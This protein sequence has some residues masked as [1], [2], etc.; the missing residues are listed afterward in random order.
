MTMV[1]EDSSHLPSPKLPSTYS[2]SS[3][4]GGRLQ[5]NANVELRLVAK[6]DLAKRVVSHAGADGTNEVDDCEDI[7]HGVASADCRSERRQYPQ[8]ERRP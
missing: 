7:A 2:A 8:Q 1:R 6:V 4:T 3:G 5:D